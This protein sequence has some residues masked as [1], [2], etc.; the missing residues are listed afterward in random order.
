MT[1]AEKRQTVRLTNIQRF[2][3]HDGPGVRTT[4]FLKG[5]SIHCPWCANPESIRYEIQSWHD[6][7]T[8]ESGQFGYDIA[9]ESLYQE[10]IKDK[11]FYIDGGGVT[12]SG[13]EPL[14]QIR[15]LEPLLKTLKDERI[16][17]A[18]ETALFVDERCVEIALQYFDWWYVDM[19]IL[20]PEQC[21]EVLGGQVEQYEKNL[22]R[23]VGNARKMCV[24]IPCC[25]GWTDT[26]ENA[27]SIVK[28]IQ[29]YAINDIELLVVHD[30]G[31]KKRETLGIE[32]NKIS[33]ENRVAAESMAHLLREHGKTCKIMHL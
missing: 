32:N 2:C 24:R 13:G 8:N 16:H 1:G 21:Q 6:P 31:K 4:V 27:D 18:V 26:P 28:A 15:R 29:R 5:C 7:A 25:R 9:L 30:M 33:T 14:L 11:S 12:F 17:L 23:I 10:I 3:V 19:K 20:P 22:S